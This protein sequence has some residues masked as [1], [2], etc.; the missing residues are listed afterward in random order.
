M[1]AMFAATRMLRGSYW[2]A[3]FFVSVGLALE[4]TRR[5]GIRS[6]SRRR[7][8]ASLVLVA[9]GATAVYFG[10]APPV[11]AAGVASRSRPLW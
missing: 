5:F 2:E 8:A 3:A 10:S 7:G 1:L 11:K 4:L 6:K 9:L